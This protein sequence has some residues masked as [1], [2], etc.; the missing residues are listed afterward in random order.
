MFSILLVEPNVRWD[1]DGVPAANLNEAGMVSPS[2][3]LLNLFVT[4][5]AVTQYTGSAVEPEVY[6]QFLI[7]YLTK[8]PNSEIAKALTVT[9]RTDGDYVTAEDVKKINNSPLYKQL[10]R[11]TTPTAPATPATPQNN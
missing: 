11:P 4:N 2:N 6:S 8:N 9:P 10:A 1:F 5:P 3:I 7:N